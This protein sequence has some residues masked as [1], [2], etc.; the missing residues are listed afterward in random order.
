M[1][2]GKTVSAVSLSG[3]DRAFMRHSRLESVKNRSKTICGLVGNW[4]SLDVLMGQFS[5]GHQSANDPNIVHFCV[6]INFFPHPRTKLAQCIRVMVTRMVEPA[7]PITDDD[8][9]F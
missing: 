3:P 5:H 6:K 2:F 1:P 7:K 8:L 9:L 4:Y